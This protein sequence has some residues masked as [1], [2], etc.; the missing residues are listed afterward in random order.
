M[1]MFLQGQMQRFMGYFKLR[2]KLLYIYWLKTME[3]LRISHLFAAEILESNFK[4]VTSSFVQ[5]SINKFETCSFSVIK[6][7]WCL[8]RMVSS[9]SYSLT[10][11]EPITF[12]SP[13]RCSNHWAT[14]TQMASEG[15]IY[16][17]VRVD[18]RH[19]YWQS[20]SLDM[21]PIVG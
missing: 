1:F 7:V 9:Y 2:L 3:T 15:Y 19:I 10:G 6:Y 21:S 14:W 8:I 5:I 17:L 12:W 4:S 11:I 16:V 20:T 13:V 18:G